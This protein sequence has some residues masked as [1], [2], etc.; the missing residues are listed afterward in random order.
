MTQ[1]HNPSHPGLVLAA[2]LDGLDEMTIS[3]FAKKIHV[4]RATLSRIIN[5]HSAITPDIAIRLELA[6]GASREMWSGLQNAYDLWKAGKK[7]MPY[8]ERVASPV[9]EEEEEICCA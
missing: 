7:R 3:D 9:V 1:M 2:W 4:T 5:G 6:L 8:I